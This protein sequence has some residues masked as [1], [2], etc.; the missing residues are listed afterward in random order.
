[1]TE[2][3]QA[4]ALRAALETP[5]GQWSAYDYD[6]VPGDLPAIYVLVTVTRRFGGDKRND[7]KLSRIGWRAT[8]LAV[9]RTA[10]EARWAREKVAGALEGKRLGDSSLID[11]DSE[12]PIEP[13]DGRWSGLTS[14]TYAT[15]P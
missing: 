4:A 6:D 10:D 2:R 8:T 11:F 5:L 13:D 15:T 1:M 9:G 14:W 3:A 12:S 7:G